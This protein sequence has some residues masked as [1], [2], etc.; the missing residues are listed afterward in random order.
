MAPT[1]RAGGALNLHIS[2]LLVCVIR[3]LVLLNSSSNTCVLPA[4]CGF[5]G[6]HTFQLH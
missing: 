3:L 6:V 2:A 4:K 1:M 5:R